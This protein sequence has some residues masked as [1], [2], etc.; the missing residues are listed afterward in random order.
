M[1]R[2]RNQVNDDIE[3]SIRSLEQSLEDAQGRTFENARSQV[4][5]L[6]FLHKLRQEAEELE[7]ELEDM[8]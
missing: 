1:R 3:Q 6:Q 8:G 5:R 2:L 4:G 7:A